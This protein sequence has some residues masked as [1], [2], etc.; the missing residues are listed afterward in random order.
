MKLWQKIFL[1]SVALTMIG[2][3]AISMSLIIRSHSL[4]LEAEKDN[5]LLK[6]N[7]I[8]AEL[9]R[10]IESEKQGY[11]LP[12]SM[13]D[14]LLT[15]LCSSMSDDRTDVSILP[16]NAEQT[17]HTNNGCT[18]TKEN[19]TISFQTVTF[20]SGT[21]YEVF[22]SKN[23]QPL[24]DQ[25][26]EDVRTAQK[27][28]IIISLFISAAL[29]FLTIMITRPIRG[30]KNATEKISSGDYSHRITYKGHDE[31][32]NLAKHMN[33]MAAHIE[34]DMAYIE[35]ISDNRRKFI[36]NMTHE[37]KTPLTS[38]LGFADVLRIKADV[39]E[40]ER[41]NYA[42]IIFTEANR[43]KI[44]SSR[45]MELI[46]VDE[47]ELHMSPVNIAELLMR[48]IEMYTPICEEAGI[49]LTT[50]L[51][52]AVIQA[53][54]TL[55]ATMIVNL[56][57]NARKASAPGKTIRISSKRMMHHVL[58]QV[59]DQGIGI[60]QEQ[61]AYVADA[62]YMVDKFRTRKA[63]G[64]GIGLALCKA[65]STAHHGELTIESVLGVGTTVS[66]VVPLYEG[67]NK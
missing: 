21:I 20:Y 24:L 52:S 50:D 2:I 67:Q 48:E 5:V 49:I 8:I 42:D 6:S 25:F 45:L 3:F 22:I 66:V 56:I 62:F 32:S 53:D 39:S 11:F 12:S 65:I 40:E 16:L 29:L 41:K 58:I 18:F 13:T 14:E 47:V 51:D 57:D 34:S 31:F 17:S 7:E 35:S 64:A 44:L 37:L 10:L 55:F 15:E 43:L 36:A 27:A 63:G 60:P 46:T 30:L 54:D 26:E 9:E 59:K 28:G 1:P 19:G 4:Q 23:V 33:N 61:L 38:I